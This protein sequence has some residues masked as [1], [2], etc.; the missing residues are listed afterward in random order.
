MIFIFDRLYRL[1]GSKYIY[2]YLLFEIVS[3]LTITAGTVGLLTLYGDSSARDF[4]LVMAVAMGCTLIAVTIGVLKSK[5]AA[6]PLT[7]WVREPRGGEA[8]L[9]A[10]RTAV[11]LPRAFVLRT[12]WLPYVVAAIPTS[13][14]ATW[15]GGLPW[16]NFL[17]LLAGASV[18]IGYAIVL[19]FFASELAARP[20]LKDI[21]R[22]LPADFASPP[23]GA[24]LRL[25]L[26]GAL[27]LIN[28]VTGVVVSALSVT[29]RASLT[30]LG[31]DVF[32]A[33]VIAFTISFELTL[34][35]TKSILAPID[36]LL[37][38]TG[39][40]KAGDLSTRVPVLS[41]D[42]L[43]QLAGSFNEMMS[44]LEER[45]T[46]REAFGS[47]V[48]PAVAERVLEEGELLEGE[49]IEASVMFVDIRDFTAW[50]E[51]ASAREAVA[52]LNEFFDTVVP[53]LG[54]HGGHANKFIGDGLLGVFGA[55]ERHR[56]HADRAL[57]A[58]CEIAD[59]CEGRF[60]VGVG[61]NSGPVMVGSIGG[62]GRLE[63]TVIGDPV[64]VASRVEALT[65]ETNDT[66]LIT[67]A[68]RCL[69]TGTDF[70]VEPRGEVPVKGKS[71]PIPVYAPKL[72]VERDRNLGGEA[73]FSS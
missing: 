5:Q 2:A 55:P 48:D 45:E 32:V 20:V 59:R 36:D 67:E 1:L 3:A 25:K 6:R 13:L 30:D 27:P 63:F 12:G 50:A 7:A 34:L 35:L 54:E 18:A 70:A 23:L 33:V 19:H 43:G 29:D 61:V 53:V 41:G 42:E 47:Y 46:L 69:L 24:S 11:S 57:A 58:A 21:S 31:L 15:I 37:E 62:G 9:D 17:I 64:N 22:H 65:R 8:A 49:E 14:F 72:P 28:I 10:W 40:V 26:L 4:G 51:R 38:A 68:T 52:Y 60:D 71:E 44:G 39:R 66:V 16:W 73:L 56:D